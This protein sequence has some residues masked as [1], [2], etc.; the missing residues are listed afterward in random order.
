MEPRGVITPTSTRADG[1]GTRPLAGRPGAATVGSGF[2]R[3]RHTRRFESDDA[4]QAN[5][6][7]KD[8]PMTTKTVYSVGSILVSSWGYDQTNIDFYQVVGFTASGKSVRLRP[9]ASEHVE[10]CGFMSEKVRPV[11]HAYTG[12]AF[13]KRINRDR[14]YIALTSYSYACLADRETYTASHYA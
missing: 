6:Q 3:E 2:K 10:S 7:Q 8:K 4:L 14:D 5:N 11:P 12:P 1:S 13:T 9:I